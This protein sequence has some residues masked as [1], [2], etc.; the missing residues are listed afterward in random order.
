MRRASEFDGSKIDALFADLD[1][2]SGPGAAVGIAIGGKPVYR[3]GYGLASMELPVVLSPSIRMRI[4]STTKHFT[5][6][7]YMLLCEEGKAGIDDPLGKYLPELNPV[8]HT[9]TTR[10]L[11]TN[12]S[13]LRDT[14]DIRVHLQG[15]MGRRATRADLVS[16]YRDIDDVHAVPGSAWIYNNGG[17][18]LL[19]AVIE[20]LTGQPFEEA[21]LSRIFEP[22]G[23]N[24][25]LVRAWD[26]DFIPN[27]A[28]PHTLNSEGGLE[29]LFWD[30]DFAGAGTIASTVDDMLR[31]CANMEAH[32]VGNAATWAAIKTPQVLPNGASTCYGL[33]LFNGRYRGVD[34]L[35]HPGGYT[36]CGSQ[37]IKVPAAGL[38]VVVLANSDGANCIGLAY[39]ILDAT[40]P[41]LDPIKKSV[42]G[43]IA[44]G[45]FRSPATGRIAHLFANEG[46]QVIAIDAM[47]LPFERNEAGVLWPTVE[48]GHFRRA[49]TLIGDSDKPSALHLSDFGVADELLQVRSDE[50]PA[51]AA[52]VGHYRSD[53]TGTEVEIAVSGGDSLLRSTGRFGSIQYRLER[54]M[55]GVWQATTL[56]A[57][58][59]HRVVLAFEDAGRGFH[60]SAFATRSLP[61]KRVD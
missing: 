28:T 49:V 19:T 50:G 29:R 59:P 48:S 12:T 24:D 7:A 3:K 56:E 21:M 26:N 47:E 11:M 51:A 27:S 5:A 60:F 1:Q 44:T 17:W 39:S 15:K 33:G 31:W 9:V 45:V 8:T 52:I 10:Q 13:G 46:Q 23:M 25:T 55:G 57:A 4:G 36:G 18:V 43:S 54:L 35:H 37:L 32:V 42:A 30:L 34:I 53:S 41:N 58:A 14:C 20:R 16:L 38:D 2:G 40:L 22:L 6:L 61:F